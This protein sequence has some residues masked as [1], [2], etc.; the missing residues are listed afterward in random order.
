[1]GF[2]PV[3]MFAIQAGMGAMGGFQDAENSEMN[4]A[5]A[6]VWAQHERDLK[7]SNIQGV[8]SRFKQDSEIQQL[9]SSQNQGRLVANTGASGAIPTGSIMDIMA[10]SIDNGVAQ[11]QLLR[12][13]ALTG[14][15]K[16]TNASNA[17]IR[18]YEDEERSWLRKADQQES[19][20]MFQ[21][22]AA[23]VAGASASGMF[24]APAT[25]GTGGGAFGG[26]DHKTFNQ[27]FGGGGSGSAFGGQSIGWGGDYGGGAFGGPLKPWNSITGFGNESPDYNDLLKIGG[28]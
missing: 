14:V 5:T 6:A 20:A 2:D 17:K 28:T 3:T 25:S 19:T 7:K 9:T 23:G 18:Q 22:I 11:N 1:M 10:H 24:T 15:A 16:I 12:S 4:A 27:G 13:Q 21:L 26:T 8:W